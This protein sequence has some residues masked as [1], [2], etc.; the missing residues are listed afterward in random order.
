MTAHL[1]L[2]VGDVALSV[3]GGHCAHEE[4]AT[5]QHG[6]LQPG[7]EAGLQLEGQHIALVEGPACNLAAVEGDGGAAC[8]R[9][10]STELDPSNFC[11]H[12]A[13][14]VKLPLATGEEN[15]QGTPMLALPSA[16]ALCKHQSSNMLIIRHAKI[17]TVLRL[18]RIW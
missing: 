7:A 17:Q 16:M 14:P 18:I 6:E 1:E 9:S 8:T 12:A 15:Q 3:G 13:V 10:C 2:L 11:L 4:W 5:G